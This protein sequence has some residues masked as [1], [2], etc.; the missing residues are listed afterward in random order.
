[1]A[2]TNINIWNSLRDKFPTFRNHTSKGTAD[3]F[4]ERGYEALKN[5]DISAIDEFYGLT[6]RVYL[7]FVNVQDAKDPFSDKG[8]GES[9]D[10]PFGAI[11]QRMSVDTVKPVS[12]AYKGLKD[13]D[14]PNP[15]VVRKA[16]VKER[17]FRQNFDYQSLITVPDDFVMKSIFINEYGMDDFMTGVMRSLENG[18]KVQNYL[19]KLEALNAYIN[20]SNYPLQA[21]QLYNVQQAGNVMT[22]DELKAF[23]IATKNAV[24]GMQIGAQT[25]A[26][27]SYKFKTTQDKG[28]LKML[29]R[30]GYSTLLSTE[31]LASTFHDDRLALD[32]DYIVVENFGG[33]QPYQEAA[34]TTPLYPVFD[35]LG[36]VIGY[37]TVA[38]SSDVTV[39]EDKV[40]WKD[41]NADVV[42][43]IADKGLLF[44]GKQ[45]PYQVEPIRNPRGRYTNMWASS[46]NNTVA[47]DPIYNA[48]VFKKVKALK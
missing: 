24:E 20:S 12:P 1:M 32:I 26:F 43:M 40:F 42:A 46:P 2:L 39:T 35:D 41:P 18:W 21:T 11:L 23:V 9:Y 15:F 10:V 14:A 22:A 5:S 48:V 25:D 31:V 44:E 16:P 33:L 3:L 34:F 36:V 19:N 45:N 17:F 38:G 8:F 37:N 30:A 27:N 4:T 7:Q 29:I 13:G 28:R 47:V 6:L